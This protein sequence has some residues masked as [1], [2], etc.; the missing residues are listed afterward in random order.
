MQESEEDVYVLFNLPQPSAQ[1]AQ[2]QPSWDSPAAA[3]LSLST[4]SSF[5]IA[6]KGVTSQPS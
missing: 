2:Q 5:G 4:S 3:L 6:H 1:R